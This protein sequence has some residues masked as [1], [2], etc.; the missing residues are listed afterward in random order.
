[1]KLCLSFV[2]L[3]LSKNLLSVYDKFYHQNDL[4]IAFII[5]LWLFLKYI[6]TK[7][8]KLVQENIFRYW[9]KNHA[10]TLSSANYHQSWIFEW[11]LPFA[12][13]IFLAWPHSYTGILF[14]QFKSMYTT[15]IMCSLRRYPWNARKVSP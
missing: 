10:T 9:N 3:C 8:K 14:G 11:V 1:M 12:K 5:H 7:Q 4:N 6:K 2:N 15:A 13:L